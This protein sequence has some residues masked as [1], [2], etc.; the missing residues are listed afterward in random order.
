MARLRQDGPV[1]EQEKSVNAAAP[2]AAME[3]W[4]TDPYARHEARWISQGTPTNLVRDGKI[5]GTDSVTDEPFQ[6][7][8]VRI[9]GDGVEPRDGSD[10]RRA[11]DAELEAPYD[12]RRAARSAWD[13]F[14][15]T[16]NGP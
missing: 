1:P 6:V 12:A 14:D 15:Q 11:D 4:Y 7:K 3:G 16:L 2:N 8:P 13:A 9:E 5:E 10:M